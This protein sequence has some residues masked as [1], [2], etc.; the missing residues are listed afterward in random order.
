MPKLS[1]PRI[2][3]VPLHAPSRRLTRRELEATLNALSGMLAG[4]D[5]E[6]DWGPDTEREDLEGAQRKLSAQLER[7]TRR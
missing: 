4:E 1:R 3:G 7:L 5:K 6:G 2:L